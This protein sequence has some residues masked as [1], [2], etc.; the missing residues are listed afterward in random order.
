MIMNVAVRCAK[1]SPMFGHIASSQTECNRCSRSVAAMPATVSLI[2]GRACSQGGFGSTVPL[3]AGTIFT[4]MRAS[5]SRL[6]LPCWPSAVR[7]SV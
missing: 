1:H 4:G 2:I 7:L 3:S 5:L 6:R